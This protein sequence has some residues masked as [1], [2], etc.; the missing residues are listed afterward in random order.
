MRMIS[1]IIFFPKQ[2]WC[3]LSHM[4]TFVCYLSKFPGDTDGPAKAVAP[5]QKSLHG[6]PCKVSERKDVKVAQDALP[7]YHCTVY[8]ILLQKGKQRQQM[9][10]K[11]IFLNKYN[12]IKIKQF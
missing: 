2:A 3:N 5:N 11:H 8:S 7:C 9:A 1:A 4:L 12:K 10:T 6:P